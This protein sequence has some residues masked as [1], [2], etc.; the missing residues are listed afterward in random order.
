MS[1]E[2]K[3]LVEVIETLEPT[4]TASEVNSIKEWAAEKVGLVIVDMESQKILYATP[5][6]EEI[7]GYMRDELTGKD[8]IILVPDSFKHVHPDHVKGF[9]EEPKDRSMGKR[10]RPL[11]GKKR[12]GTQF[13]A[14]IGLFPRQW[15]KYRLCLANVVQL[16]KED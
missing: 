8:L 14:E 1:D 5:G 10:D 13:P 11:Y 9:N 2:L 12:D 3:Q 7:F 4:L 15:K 16:M 6:A